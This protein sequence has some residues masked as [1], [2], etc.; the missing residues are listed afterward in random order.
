MPADI[1]LR[2]LSAAHQAYMISRDGPVA[3]A[4]EGVDAPCSGCI[5][6]TQGG[7]PWGAQSGSFGQNAAMVGSIPEGVVVAV[8]GTTPPGPGHD[9]LQ[10]II[11][12]AGDAVALLAGAAGH[13]PGFP[14][15]VH[16]GFYK[17][18]MGVWSKL[19]QRVDDAVKAHPE[20]AIFVT[21]HSKGGAISPLMAW[22]LRLDYPDHQIVVRTFAPARIGDIDFASAYA[23]AIT[24]HIRFEYDDD[25]VPHMPL[26]PQLVDALGAPSLVGW[27]LSKADLGYGAVGTLA[28]IRADGTI[29]GD[30]P[31][32]EQ[33]RVDRLAAKL[34]AGQ[35]D[36]V[37]SCHGMS[38]PTDGYVRGAYA[39]REAGPGVGDDA[40]PV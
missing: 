3:A 15:K 36:Y 6:W 1:T 35:V 40:P 34:A 2:L 31:Q 27:L 14:G 19:H 37:I 17:A 32:L 18:F 21:G 23:A 12:W 25:I 13:P 30:S 8:R 7:A 4:G 5:G 11:D 10:V 39:A 22:R 33:D 24:D 16:F 26:E 20:K 28:Y 29:C 9:P 38:A